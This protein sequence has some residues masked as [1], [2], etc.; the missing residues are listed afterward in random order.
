MEE[1]HRAERVPEL[2]ADLIE[3]LVPI[4]AMLVVEDAHLADPASEVVLTAVARRTE[5]HPWLLLV[6]RDDR[7]GGWVPT[8]ARRIEL[9]PLDMGSSRELAEMATPERPLPPAVAEA[10]AARSGGHPLLLRELARAVARGE[11]PDELPSTVEE[12]A[13]S[14]IDRLPPAQRSLLRRAAV[15]GDEFDED[16]LLRMV[17]DVAP[18]RSLPELL[19]G[20]QGLI[21][22]EDHGLRFRHAILREVAYAGLPYQRR[23]ELHA[24]AAEVL[25]ATT[26]F[27]DRR[28]E[29]LALHYFVAG[30]YDRAMEYGWRAGERAM[31]RHAPAA[32]DAYRRAA[33][34]ARL[35]S[36]VSPSERSFYL[37]ALGDA[38]FLAGRSTEAAPPKA[39]RGVH[40]Q[41]LRDAH[42]ALK[43]TRVEQR[44]GHHTN[45]LRRAS[46]GLRALGDATGPEAGAARARLQARY[47][48]CRLSQGRYGDARGW[49]ER[50]LAEAEAADQLDA[51]AE[52]HLVLDA[53]RCGPADPRAS[54]TRR[55]RCTSSSS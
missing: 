7:P 40:E 3:R 45:A 18:Q 41:P 15:L 29:V 55:Q 51:Q 2:V 12:L 4:P 11:D 38:Q 39:L 21:V 50:A 23:R 48:F 13:A 46:L 32:A 6:T 34:A 37:E 16:L 20:L 26:S 54:S 8:D 28:P 42:L 52:A 14:Q 22:A 35:S 44:R 17:G 47:A 36:G 19:A 9:G 1:L 30:R 5:R 31:E 10:L 27:A 43:L 25:E 53:W 24:R 49:A 33:Q